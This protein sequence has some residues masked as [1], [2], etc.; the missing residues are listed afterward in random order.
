MT[1][2]IDKV[3]ARGERL[4]L[5]VDKTEDLLANVREGHGARAPMKQA[6]ARTRLARAHVPATCMALPAS[7]AWVALPLRRVPC[8]P[9]AQAE[10]FRKASNTIKRVIWWQN[11]K[12][13]LIVLLAVLLL[14]LVVFL[15]VC[16][17]GRNCLRRK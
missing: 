6:R 15:L 3:L 11:M 13:R 2:N 16:F 8:C 9:C 14:T 17:S 12:M 1:E 5:L 4:A 10:R 7:W